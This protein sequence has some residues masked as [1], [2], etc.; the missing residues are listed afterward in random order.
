MTLYADRE[1]AARLESMA[2]RDL[3]A[4][5]EAA[6]RLYPEQR[7]E[8]LEVRDGIAAFCGADSA[9]NGT[10][11]LGLHS[12]VTQADVVEIEQFFLDRDARP[13]VSVCPLADA[14][15]PRALAARRWVIADFENVLARDL[16][17][18]EA[19]PA[20]D[21]GIEIRVALDA[22]DRSE[23]AELVVDGFSAPGTP[24]PAETR[25]GRI[26][27]AMPDR[28][29]LT[30][31][32][33]GVPAG[34]GELLIADDIGWLSADTTLPRFRGRGVQQSLQRVRLGM[35]RDAGC[36]IAVTESAPGSGSQRNMER[37]GFRVVYTRTEVAGPLPGHEL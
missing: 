14:S 17:G 12:E 37:V 23:W 22:G 9:V 7:P 18:A 25:L 29:F 26:L 34:T 32:I 1:L 24:S 5:A 21:P 15:L 36:T 16:T 20:P 3:R 19:L 8:W 27:G 31:L 30:A 11:G 6:T 4:F 33:D 13:L 10:V 28:V 35:A 2:A